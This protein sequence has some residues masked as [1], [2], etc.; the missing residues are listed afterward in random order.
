M[1]RLHKPR[2]V[3]LAARTASAPA[4]PAARRRLEG[5]PRFGGRVAEFTAWPFAARE[6]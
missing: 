4:Q 2:G 1:T 3:P 6:N 5:L